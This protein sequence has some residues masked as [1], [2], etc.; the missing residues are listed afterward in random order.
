[1]QKHIIQSVIISTCITMSVVAMVSVATSVQA[2]TL[3]IEPL[4]GAGASLNETGLGNINPVTIA[5]QSINVMLQVLGLFTLIIFMY[6]GFLWIWARGNEEQITKAK[7]IL[8]GTF[9]G[10]II[11]LASYGIMQWVY[12]YL[13]A[14]T[15][16]K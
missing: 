1:M 14:I 11:I 5:A 3:S 4:W 13:I 6:G 10:L 8:Q 9:I 15:N 16:A 2:A 7:D 12:Y